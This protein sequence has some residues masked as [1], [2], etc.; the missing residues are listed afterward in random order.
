M[1]QPQPGE[2]LI[3][4]LPLPERPESLTILHELNKGAWGIVY[5]GVFDGRQVAVKA[6]HDALV[7]D[8]EGGDI[9]VRNFCKECD[10]L[11]ALEHN[12]VISE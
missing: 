1:A 2:E 5:A 8:V 6:I 4:S 12:H 11:K 7:E 3:E 9:T 10:R